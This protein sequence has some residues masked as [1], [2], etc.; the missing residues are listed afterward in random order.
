MSS[1][2]DESWTGISA[3]QRIYWVEKGG[4]YFVHPMYSSLKVRENRY[5]KQKY[6]YDQ[7]LPV[8]PY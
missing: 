7:D 5:Q 8:D 4:F 2:Y 1:L 6:L 3:L